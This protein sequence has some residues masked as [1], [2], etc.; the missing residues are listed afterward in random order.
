MRQSCPKSCPS[1]KEPYSGF[2]LQYHQAGDTFVIGHGEFNHLIFVVSGNLTVDSEECRGYQV[3]K[4]KFFFCYNCGHYT[5]TAQSDLKII[6]AHFA[7]PGAACD[8]ASLLQYAKNQPDFQYHFEAVDVNEPMQQM[9]DMLLR[10]IEDDVPCAHMHNSMIEL[11]FVVF[12]FYYD[13]E[14][15]SNLF[16]NLFDHAVSFRTMV[17]GNRIKARNLNHLAEL[18]GYDIN[19][20]NV[21]FRRHYPG[22]TPG[23][24]MQIQRKDEIL[25]D[26]I[27]TDAPIYYISKKYGFSSSSHLGEYCKKYLGD[28]PTKVR[29]RHRKK[30]ME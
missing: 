19:T 13:V 20:F 11:L 6:V 15:L 3:T 9:L 30:K 26:L 22:Y 24:W 4:G 25:A 27:N 21:V 16:F 28:T 12:R 8:I 10:F 14:V 23:V 1:A 7:R 29:A 17:E 2:A 18:C 5:I